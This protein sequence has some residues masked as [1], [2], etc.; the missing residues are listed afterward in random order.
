MVITTDFVIS[1]PLPLNKSLNLGQERSLLNTSMS[2]GGKFKLWPEFPFPQY[3]KDEFLDISD[4]C[5]TFDMVSVSLERGI[6]E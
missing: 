4:R 2:Q 5:E 6:K 1:M 3:V